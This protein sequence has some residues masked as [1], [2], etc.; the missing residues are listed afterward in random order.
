[1]RV[2]P[3]A[4]GTPGAVERLPG[5]QLEGSARP[6]GSFYARNHSPS[7]FSQAG[8][9]LSD[10]RLLFSLHP[11]ATLHSS[12]GKRAAAAISDVTYLDRKSTRLNSSHL[13]ISYAVFC[14]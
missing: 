4:R 10:V 8:L 6:Q 11:G 9:F 13:G 14:L 5:R 7:F 12:S 1:M 2:C 3:P